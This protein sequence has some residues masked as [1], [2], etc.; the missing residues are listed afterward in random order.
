MGPEFHHEFFMVAEEA[1]C[2]TDDQGER[3]D[4]DEDGPPWGLVDSDDEIPE[5][6]DSSGD[7]QIPDT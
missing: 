4:S 3:A 2:G 6:I 5:L 7:E 1:V